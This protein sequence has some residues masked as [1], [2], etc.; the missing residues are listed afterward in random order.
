MKSRLQCNDTEMYST[1]K[2][3]IYIVSERFIRTLKNKFYKY[4]IPLSEKMYI[5]KLG[6]IVNKCNNTFHSTIRKKLFY[7]KS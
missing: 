3:G 6:D 1:Y 2:E 7:V 5:D 4:M